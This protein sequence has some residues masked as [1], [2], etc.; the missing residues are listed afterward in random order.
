M[1][2]LASMGLMIFWALFLPGSVSADNADLYSVTGVDEDDYLNVR[3]AANAQS[4][5][6]TRIPNDGTGIR[7]LDGEKDQDGQIWWR[8]K[9]EGK[10]GWV[11][12][13]YL[14]TP[15]TAGSAT[16]SKSDGKADDS[17]TALHC[18][19]NE[20]FWGIKITKKN[21]IY[22]PLDGDILNLPIII[23]KTSENNTSIAAVYAKKSAD[24][25]TAVLQ[26]VETCSDGMSDIDYPYSISAMI[27]NQKFYSGCCHVK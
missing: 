7:R 8:I 2:Q 23:N 5:I 3:E 10:Q 22:S 12:K 13:R 4:P 16:D 6:V 26:K 11:N 9:W 24:S 17:K 25:V 18:G 14:I 1:K 20:P 15:K 19:G 27:N 21:L